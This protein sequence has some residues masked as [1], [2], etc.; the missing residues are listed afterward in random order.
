M[1]IHFLS[2]LK[3][4][5]TLRVTLYKLHFCFI[6]SQIFKKKVWV[7]SVFNFHVLSV[8]FFVS[9]LLPLCFEKKI[10]FV[11]EFAFIL[12]SVLWLRVI[13]FDYITVVYMK[14]VLC[15]LFHECVASFISCFWYFAHYLSFESLWCSLPTWFWVIIVYHH[16]RLPIPLITSVLLMIS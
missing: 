2:Q 10:M 1:T 13:V 15:A 9:V 11:W 12:V 16:V 4:T 3:L 7:F 6:S 8:L 14:S 5:Q